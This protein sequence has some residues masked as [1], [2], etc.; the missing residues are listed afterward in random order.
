MRTRVRN[1]FT[2]EFGQR[3]VGAGEGAPPTTLPLSDVR[4]VRL[5][6]QRP[7]IGLRGIRIRATAPARG[8]LERPGAYNSVSIAVEVEAVFRAGAQVGPRARLGRAFAPRIRALA[9]L[10][11]QSQRGIR[12]PAQADP[13]PPCR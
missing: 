6:R 3:V 2:V 10:T 4:S 7:L 9:A 5:D 13:E 8:L 11:R 12:T 1:G